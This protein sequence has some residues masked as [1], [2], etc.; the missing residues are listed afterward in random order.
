[1]AH[2]PLPVAPFSEPDIMFPETAPFAVMRPNMLM[3]Q[4]IWGPILSHGADV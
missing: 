3:G 1:M 2:R 4:G